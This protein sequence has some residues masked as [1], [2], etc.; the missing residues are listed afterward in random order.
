M[1]RVA[2]IPEIQLLN[3]FGGFFTPTEQVMPAQN[4]KITDDE[5]KA[6]TEREI[7]NALGFRSGKLAESRRKAMQYYLGRPVGDLSPPEIEG[8]SSVVDTSVADT[9]E[10]M[11]PTLLKIFTAGDNVVEFAPQNQ[12]DE[13]KAKQATEYINYIFYRQNP[14]WQILYNWIKDALI[15]KVGVLKVW[16]DEHVEE[17]REEYSGLSDTELAMLLQDEQIEPKEHKAYD[18]PQA[19]QQKQQSLQQLQQQA[20]ANPQAAAQMQQVMQMPT[21]QLHD[22]TLIR[23]ENQSQ[24]RIE[25]V[26]AEEFLISRTAK[27]LDDAPFVAHQVMR[28]ISD[29]RARGYQNVD[30]IQSDDTQAAFSLERIERAQVDDELAGFTVGYDSAV[31][32]DSQR[33][34]WI[35]ECYLRCDYD[36]DGIAE[37][38]KVVRAANVILENV[39]CDG[40]PF[41]TICP[42]PIPHR[43]FGLSIADLAMETQKTKTN[44]L[45]AILDNLYLQVNGRYFAV[46]GQVN[47]DDLLTS[48]PG[49]VVR[50]KNP[51]AVGR[52]DQG[53]V[54]A[55]DA[56]QM[57]E[58]C[59]SWKENRTGW[60]RYSQGSTGDS[61]NKTATG[62]NIVTNRGDM[63]LDLIA[64]VF[65]ETGFQRLFTLILKLICQHQK[66]SQV[67]RLTGGWQEIDPTEWRNKFDLNINVGLGTGNK[68]QQVQHLMTLLQVQRE[69]MA[70]GVADPSKIYNAASKLTE[71]LG[72]KDP[73]RFFSD[74]S[75]QPPQPPKPD[76]EMQKMQMQM[77]A[78]QQKAVADMQLQREKLAAETQLAREKLEAEIAL[79]REDMVLKYKSQQESAMYAALYRQ[80]EQMIDGTG[81]GIE[82]ESGSQPWAASERVA[83]T[84]ADGGSVFDYP[85]QPDPGMGNQPGA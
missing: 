46:D 76:P 52:L 68:D 3:R 24:V 62:I 34:V 48:R 26:P 36:G 43:F 30:Q 10:W 78:D 61:L 31:I 71:S 22:V 85:Q 17:T 65:A 42:V 1:G 33:K 79:K 47:L 13:E 44:I 80:S 70:I 55:R 28:S 38:R 6:I 11:L 81:R 63:R 58:Y 21:P 18:D 54:D 23:R 57:I 7:R 49:G 41:V 39:E 53:Q 51:G 14:G 4:E 27:T 5:I 67:V 15:E 74:P 40:P 73:E 83:G 37:W 75:K 64:R 35:T 45:R 84:P 82:A 60:T 29:L 2:R 56:Y 32:D 66:K 50:I 8:R 77:Q 12:G 59:E 25:N 20:Q 72:F 69:A 16:W 9:V 19:A